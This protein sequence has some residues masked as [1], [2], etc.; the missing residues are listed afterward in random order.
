MYLIK[1]RTLGVFG[2]GEIGGIEVETLGNI[3]DFKDTVT[4][5]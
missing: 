4:S 2:F 3:D 5:L 1:I